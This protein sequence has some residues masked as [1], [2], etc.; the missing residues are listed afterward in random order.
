MFS[1]ACVIL[2]TWGGGHCHRDPLEQ[3]HPH[4]RKIETPTVH[5]MTTTEAGGTH[6]TGMH[7]SFG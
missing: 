2:S 4:P 7:T 3:R 5:L 6:P 1:Q